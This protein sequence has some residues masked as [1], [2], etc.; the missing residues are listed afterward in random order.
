MGS[1]HAVGWNVLKG[2]AR[3]H[4]ILLVTQDNEF[5]STLEREIATLETGGTAVKAFF[6]RHGSRADGRRNSLRLMYYLTYAVWQWRVFR[7]AQRLCKDHDVRA[8]HHLT[9]VGFREPGFLWMLDQPFIWG[10]VGGL[11]FAPRALFP[12]LTTK[13]K[14][15][16]LV[17]NVATALQFFC[18]PRVALA[19]RKA[20][21]GGGRF[22]AAT[23]DIGRRFVARFGGT[24]VRVPETGAATDVGPARS[25]ARSPGALRL[26]WVG[27]LIERKPLTL[28][29]D[30]IA[31]IEGLR[32]HV[33]LEVIGDG[34]TADD[35]RAIASARGVS[36]RFHGWRGYDEVQSMY[37]RGDLFVL[38][39]V[40]DLTTNVVFEALAHGLPV[41]CLDHHG[42]SEIVDASC[43]FKIPIT[44]RADLTRAVSALL[45]D[46][47]RDPS[48]LDPL[49]RGAIARAAQ[50]TWEKNVAMIAA[51]HHDVA[52]AAS[53][54][55]LW[56]ECEQSADDD[57][58]ES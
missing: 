36:A 4:N 16:A 33:E 5:R 12:F 47:A 52:A 42:Y 43:G 6:V 20:T 24:Y 35:Y 27:A 53:T 15:F 23:N 32:D 37:A 13:M 58:I 21:R 41:L 54:A 8:V 34:D 9:I 11:V 49:R 48:R 31:A 25:E 39:S 38:F 2:L 18:S 40:T 56:A 57:E 45:A 28:L 19:Y 22:I 29:L 7:L 51:A 10:P 1:E 44:D 55:R 17:R 26:V 14:V 3:T 30:A 46:L 50:Y